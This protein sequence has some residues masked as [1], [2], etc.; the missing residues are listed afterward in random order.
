MWLQYLLV[1]RSVYVP[2]RAAMIDFEVGGAGGRALGSAAPRVADA[3][4]ANGSAD[5]GRCMA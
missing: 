5:V 2:A 4:S 1:F 3:I